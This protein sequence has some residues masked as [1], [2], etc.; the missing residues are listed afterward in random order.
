MNSTF[1]CVPILN[2]FIKSVYLDLSTQDTRSR[3][4]FKDGSIVQGLRLSFMLLIL[5]TYF[6]VFIDFMMLEVFQIPFKFLLSEFS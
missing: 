2:L 6:S 4:V 1:G 5:K 3:V